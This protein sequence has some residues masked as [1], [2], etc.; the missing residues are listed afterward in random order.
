MP[1]QALFANLDQEDCFL[2]PSSK[3]TPWIISLIRLAPLS[4]LHRFCADMASLQTIVKHAS[5]LPARLV[6]LVPSLS[7]IC[8]DGE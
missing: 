7:R 4:A 5:R 1:G 6:F 8:E 3:T 2:I